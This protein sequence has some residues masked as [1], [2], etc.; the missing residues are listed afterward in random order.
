MNINGREYGYTIEPFFDKV[1]AEIYKVSDSELS[2]GKPMHIHM[3]KKEFGGFFRGIR[4]QDY[5]EAKEWVD[6]QMKSI[7]HANK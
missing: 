4:E 5:I 7:Y 6:C 3:T 1:V 2:S